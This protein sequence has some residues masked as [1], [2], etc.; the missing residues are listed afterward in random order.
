MNIIMVNELIKQN[1]KE[2]LFYH[3]NYLNISFLSSI[4]TP[5]VSPL[6]S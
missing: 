3:K 2:A 5:E 4:K 6:S 1:I